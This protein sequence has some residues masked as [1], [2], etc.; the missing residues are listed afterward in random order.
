MAVYGDEDERAVLGQ[1]DLARIDAAVL[2]RVGTIR[3]VADIESR[4]G[5][6]LQRLAG[7]RRALA[8]L[9]RHLAEEAEFF[10]GRVA[11]VRLGIFVDGDEEEFRL[12]CLEDVSLYPRRGGGGRGADLVEYGRR[13][14]A[15]HLERE[16]ARL[17]VE[18]GLLHLHGSRFLG[19]R[20]LAEI[21]ADFAPLV[22]AGAVVA[23]A[24]H[25]AWVKQRP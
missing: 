11:L 13:V 20:P 23:Q 6:Q 15:V 2:L 18:A 8:V 9:E 12:L 19:E 7:R 10:A 24:V 1:D 22:G 25:L 3:R 16:L 21:S 5:F 14:H 4:M 17:L